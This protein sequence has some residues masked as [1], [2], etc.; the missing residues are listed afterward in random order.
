MQIP[1]THRELE[2]LPPESPAALPEPPASDSGSEATSADK[3]ILTL[4]DLI[5]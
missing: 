4:D 1:V 5:D 3:D 2:D